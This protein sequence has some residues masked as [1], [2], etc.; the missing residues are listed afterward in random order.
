MEESDILTT[1]VEE[2]K[3]SLQFKD[4]QH[5]NQMIDSIHD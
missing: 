4:Q 2:L 3:I 5:L 1:Q